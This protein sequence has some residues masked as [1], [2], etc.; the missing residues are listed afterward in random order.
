MSSTDAELLCRFILGKK[1]T[2]LVS[3]VDDGVEGT[4]TEQGLYEKSL[5]IPLNF[6]PNLKLLSKNKVFKLQVG[7]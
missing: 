6:A 1:Y 5:Y 3:D 4:C 2:I 7:K